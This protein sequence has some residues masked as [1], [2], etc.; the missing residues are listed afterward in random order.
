MQRD[1]KSL[2]FR[3]TRASLHF[4]RS[5]TWKVDIAFDFCQRAETVACRYP[6]EKITPHVAY[7]SFYRYN[8][9]GSCL[10]SGGRNMGIFVWSVE[11]GWEGGDRVGIV[12]FRHVFSRI[13][14]PP[15]FF[16]ISEI[17]VSTYLEYV[18]TRDECI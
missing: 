16:K 7:R 18:E 8:G 15:F 10:I 12:K 11:D 4:L 5:K 17:W 2:G 3:P 6:G 13:W 9:L 1:T 14:W